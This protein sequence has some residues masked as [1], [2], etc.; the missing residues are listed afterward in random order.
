MS[1]MEKTV[2]TLD[3]KRIPKCSGCELP[4]N[5]H[6]W[7]GPSPHCTGPDEEYLLPSHD[8]VIDEALDPE[9]VHEESELLAKL[10]WWWKNNSEY[11]N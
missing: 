8:A 7:A 9:P 5:L 10:W 4:Y 2:Q 3:D 11:K 6:S 1:E